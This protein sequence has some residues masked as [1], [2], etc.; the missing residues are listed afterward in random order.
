METN[1]GVEFRPLI[2]SSRT[3]GGP[4]AILARRRPGL[5]VEFEAGPAAGLRVRASDVSGAAVTLRVAGR[6]PAELG[7]LGEGRAGEVFLGAFDPGPEALDTLADGRPG[8]TSVSGPDG[9]LFLPDPAGTGVDRLYLSPNLAPLGGRPDAL[10][11]VRDRR[12]PNETA[13]VGRPPSATRLVLVASPPPPPP[14]RRTVLPPAL[15]GW[16]RGRGTP[17]GRRRAGLTVAA[18]A[19]GSVAEALS[20]ASATRRTAS[21]TSAS[22]VPGA[23]AEPDRRAQQGR[24]QAHRAEDR[25]G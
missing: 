11:V 14:A 2:P 25:R 16:P 24:R 23:E 7:R 18:F 4:T 3:E 8:A 20:T 13:R 10:W 1:F 9:F 19:H 12:F 21:S 15:S 22:V 17:A 6:A 5:V